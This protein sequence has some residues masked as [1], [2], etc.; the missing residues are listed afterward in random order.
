M[1]TKRNIS[2]IGGAGHIGF[3]LGLILGSKGFK[4]SLIDKNKNNIKKINNGEVPFLEENSKK[5]L[6]DMR[7]K[8]RIYA[9]DQINEISKSK[10]IIICISTPITNQLNPNLKPFINFFHQLKK[11]IKKDQIVIIRSSIYPGIC[12]KVYKVIAKKCKNLSYCPERIVQGKSIVELPKLPQ[13]VSGKSKKAILESGKL[14][15]TICKK[16]IYTEVIEAELIKLFSNAYRYINFAI[17]N[18]FYMICQNQNL[19]F[20]KIRNIMR[21]GYMRNANIPE[22]GFTA[23]PCL[24]KDTMQ[25]SSFY[26]HRF[27]LGH[28]AMSVNEGIPIFIIKKLQKKFD[29]RKKTVGV[30]GLTFKAETDDIRDSLSIKLVKLLELKKIKTLQSDEFYKNKK[31]ISKN[32]LVKKSDIIILATPHKAYKRLKI[33]KN[34]TVVDIWGLIENK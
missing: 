26:N 12:E 28:A 31:N 33:K 8:K 22:S 16:I 11:K 7:K 34:K 2:I 25:L 29:L 5:L 6:T 32:D 4:V 21:E 3:P 19:N 15:K 18:Q 13:L 27:K 9:T 24:L 20:F 30:L 17:S 23:G 1:S 10:Y 14:F